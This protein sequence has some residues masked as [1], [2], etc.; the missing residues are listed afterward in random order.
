MKKALLVLFVAV[1]GVLAQSGPASAAR[2]E[3]HYGWGA[4]G[5]LMQSTCTYHSGYQVCSYWE[6]A[7][8]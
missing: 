6:P 3:T 1:A 7:Q 5:T 2:S 4:D 8:S